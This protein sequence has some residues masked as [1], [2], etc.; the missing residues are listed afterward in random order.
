MDKSTEEGIGIDG[1]EMVTFAKHAEL[2]FGMPSEEHPGVAMYTDAVG[3]H[4]AAIAKIPSYLE[5]FIERF[6]ADWDEYDIAI[7]HQTAVRAIKMG[8]AEIGKHLNK[9]PEEFPEVL[10]SVDTCGNT[11]ST[12]VIIALYKALKENR[13]KEGSKVVF[14]ALASGLVLGFIS[15]RLGKLKVN[16]GV[17]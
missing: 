4:T 17:N 11:A 7:P 6:G 3:I 10:C 8:M 2:C 14:I 15:A 13:I 5:K 16:G 1:I 9:A 12:A